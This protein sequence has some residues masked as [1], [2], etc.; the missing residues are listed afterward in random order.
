MCREY[1]ERQG[2]EFLDGHI[3]SDKELSGAGADRP[4]WVRLLAVIKRRPCPFDVL[5]V[6]DTSRLCRNLGDN[7]KFTEEMAYLGIRVVAVSQGID[8][9][10]KQAKVLMT[11][12]GLAD[13]MYIEEL[14]SK[15]HRGLE[16]RALKGLNTGGRCY[17]YDNVAVPTV[18]GADGTPA[19][20]R[21]VNETEAAVIRRIFQMYAGGGSLKSITK[22]LNAEHV[23]PP[24]KRNGR[25][26]ATWCPSAIREMLRRELYAGSIIWNRRHFVKTPGTNKRVSRERPESEWLIFEQPELRII[27]AELWDSVQQRIAWVN[28]KYNYG[29]HPGLTHR[30]S[31]SHNVLTGFMKCAVCGAN[32]IIVTGRG[33]NGHHRYGCPQNFNRGACSNG[34]KERADV[35]EERLFSELQEAVLRPE[36]VAYAVEEFERQLQ[37]SLAGLDSKIGRMRQRAE[38][39]KLDIA[40]A[41]TNLIAC[42]NNPALVQ[43]I[44]TRQQELDEITGQLLGSEPN[45]VS[46][47]IG[48]IR[49][50]AM[51]RL[52]DIRQRLKVDVQ[53]AKVELEKHVKEIRMIPQ[54]E[55]NKGYYVAEGEWNLLGGYGEEAG[56]PATKR[57]RMVAGEG[58]EPSTF[59]L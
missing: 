44:N 53:K 33:K 29:N 52:G 56:N 27:D 30:A 32:L 17:G 54:V 28:K 55:G 19:V 47:E 39:L 45:S 9:Q 24:R 7:A 36:A 49:L 58:F 5:L 35:L 48:R 42:K 12:H 57:I 11:F 10:S 16:G 51:G 6:D 15:T 13:E 46:A 37:S 26:F 21:Q 22:T 41:V 40:S 8:T 20:R 34:L 4:G 31:T 14:S 25:R 18:L 59:G 50:F 1:A 38:E 43:A 2:W 3:Y 23:P